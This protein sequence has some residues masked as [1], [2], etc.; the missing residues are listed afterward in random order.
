MVLQPGGVVT[1]GL[2]DCE[3]SGHLFQ[4]GW[5]TEC[6]FPGPA[7][8]DDDPLWDRVA[9]VR[10]ECCDDPLAADIAEALVRNAGMSYLDMTSPE[11]AAHIAARVAREHL[12]APLTLDET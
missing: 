11:E 12:S 8:E 4:D 5:C 2:H 10:D 3:V 7:S 1:A 9:E 6:D